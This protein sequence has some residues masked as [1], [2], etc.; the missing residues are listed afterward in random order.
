MDTGISPA[1]GKLYEPQMEDMSM[2]PM[3]RRCGLSAT[4]EPDIG[5]GGFWVTGI[6]DDCLFTLLDVQLAHVRTMESY[7]GDYT[8]L[9]HMSHANTQGTPVA[10]I[11]GLRQENLISFY[12]PE[13]E[14]AFS[15]ENGV[16]YSSRSLCILPRF[17]DRVGAASPEDARV[18]RTVLS[19]PTANELPREISALL[20]N[21]SPRMAD[22]PG[23]EFRM[24]SLLSAIMALVLENAHA[25]KQAEQRAGSI[26]SRTLVQDASLLMQRNLSKHLTLDAIAADLC[27]SRASLAAIFK[28]E[29]GYGVAEHLKRIRMEEAA[30]LLT[31]SA[32]SVAE[33]GRAVGYPR[34]SSFTEAFRS[35]HGCTPTQFRTTSAP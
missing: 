33:V 26:S 3:R 19:S 24:T 27:V 8:C 4:M 7:A 1:L 22:M 25:G 32:A 21:V 35:Y 11:P 31:S 6:G 20:C 2:K 5:S 23:A 13:G 29:T 12:Q 15:L 34:Q 14:V 30:K 28:K 9:G 17:F 16:S 18:L 10:D